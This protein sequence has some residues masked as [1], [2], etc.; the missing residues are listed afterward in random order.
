MCACREL[1]LLNLPDAFQRVAYP[2]RL[3]KCREARD[4]RGTFGATKSRLLTPGGPQP[5]AVQPFAVRLSVASARWSAVRRV[6]FQHVVQH[7]RYP[8][9]TVVRLTERGRFSGRDRRHQQ[10]RHGKRTIDHRGRRPRAVIYACVT[11]QYHDG[12]DL[13]DL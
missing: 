5:E 8:S 4:C 7:A 12:T 13:F 3:V 9:L 1:L 6:R 11:E 2:A 10:H